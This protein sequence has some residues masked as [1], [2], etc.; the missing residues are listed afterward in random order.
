VVGRLQQEIAAS[1]KTQD[2]KN[3]LTAQALNPVGSSPEEFTRYIREEI[4]KWTRVVK[5]SGARVE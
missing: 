4:E 5:A 3:K 2:L 1:L